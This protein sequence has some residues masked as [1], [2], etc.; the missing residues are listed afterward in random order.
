MLQHSQNTLSFAIAA[1]IQNKDRSQA[2][3]KKL[4]LP[5]CNQ[6]PGE[7]SANAC[8]S[9]DYV[10]RYES[11]TKSV[12]PCL[13]LSA[14]CGKLGGAVTIDFSG[15]K[16]GHRRQFGG[17]RGQPLAKA[18]G[19]K[20]GA[21]PT[22]IDA[23]AGLGKDAFVL[24][25]L[26]AQ[27]MLIER[28]PILAALLEDGLGRASHDTELK[29]IVT[30][31]MNLIATD[32][33][34]WLTNLPTEQHPDV[35]YMDPMYPHRN[36]SALVKKEM[37]VLRE[38]IGDDEDASQLL[39]VALTWVKQRVTVKRPRTAPILGGSILNNRKPNSTVESKNTRYDIYVP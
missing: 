34:E 29:T 9:Y 1:D 24:A 5:L 27:V 28:S 36:K 30:D 18:I 6:I 26:G 22:V 11:C 2:L 37:R 16:S 15:G 14:T 13:T 10:L 19:L 8:K 38:L 39:H 12:A 33:I 20:G 7:A 35:I 25:C 17:G 32:A 23:T 31:R 3:A 4:S 21:N